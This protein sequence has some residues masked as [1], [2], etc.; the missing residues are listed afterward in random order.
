MVS[1]DKPESKINTR[2]KKINYLKNEVIKRVLLY[3]EALDRG[4]D[5]N[6]DIQRTLEETKQQLLVLQLVKD[7]ADKVNVSA[8]EIEDYY[9]RFKGE[10]K[11]PEERRIR[12]I[13]VSTRT[14]AKEILIRL[15]Q[16]EDFATLAK[17]YSIASS[18]EEGGDLG[19]I[20]LG[21]KFK[22]FDEVAFSDTL[23]VG[24]VS[25]VFK[26]PDG[27]YIIKLEGKRGGRQKSLS[28]MW[29]D[30]KRA[31]TFLKQQQRIEELVG[32]LS[33]NAKIEIK[34]DLIK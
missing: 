9:N 5:R 12:E 20:T 32:K 34:E 15:L 4:L 23:E 3:Q 31:L 33:R 16:G 27:Y 19:F 13:V 26:G 10:L 7:E 18:A 25:S 2:E 8:S 11:E 30:I 28:E 24:Q 21:K 22:E 6:P 29:N 17:E 14:Q 1:E